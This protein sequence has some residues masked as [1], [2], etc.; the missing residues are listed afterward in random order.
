[1]ELEYENSLNEIEIPPLEISKLYEKIYNNLDGINNSDELTKKLYSMIKDNNE[2]IIEFKNILLDFTDNLINISNNQ[3]LKQ[4]KENITQ[5]IKSNPKKIIDTFIIHGYIEDNALYRRRIIEGNDEFFLNNT[6]SKYTNEDSN[7]MDYIFQF[8]SFWSELDN[9]NKYIIKTFL[10]TLCYYSDKRFVL[11]NKY[12]E[13]KNIYGNIYI[14][15]FEY[16]D[17]L[18]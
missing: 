16:F 2:T 13:I 14:E 4:H 1:M 9:E 3:L 12:V 15:T 6:H 18:I 11:F 17:K 7:V 8:K 10:L 5:I